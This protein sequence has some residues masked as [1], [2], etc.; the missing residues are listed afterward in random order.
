MTLSLMPRTG[1]NND[2]FQ[3]TIQMFCRNLIRNIK[4]EAYEQFPKPLR[5][6]QYRRRPDEKTNGVQG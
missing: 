4:L 3:I 5:F 2:K 1:N 6:D